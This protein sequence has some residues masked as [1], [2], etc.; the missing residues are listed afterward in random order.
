MTDAWRRGTR[1]ESARSPLQG[2]EPRGGD[3]DAGDRGDRRDRRLRVGVGH[4][5]GDP[6]RHRTF[7]VRAAY[8]ESGG[9]PPAGPDRGRRANPAAPASP[10]VSPGS[11]GPTG[12]RRRGKEHR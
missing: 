4:P 6:G 5:S 2:G 3:P 9:R 11:D 7:E 8:R 12:G 10:R 1:D